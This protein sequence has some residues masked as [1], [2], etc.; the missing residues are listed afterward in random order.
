[1][2]AKT[3]GRK[4]RSGGLSQKAQ[5]GILIG[6]ACVLL[7]GGG[8]WGYFK[9]TTLP[10]PDLKAAPIN[11]VVAFMGNERGLIR[12]G[13]DQREQYL[14]QAYRHY[15]QG[16][17]RDQFI[18]QLNRMSPSEKQVLCDAVFDITH[19]KVVAA[20]RQYNDLPPSQRGAF[21]DNTIKQF[22]SMRNELG[23]GSAQNSVAQPMKS[24]L[25]TSSDE[26]SKI[27]VSRTSGQERAEAKPFVD[28]VA[29]RYKEMRNQ[30]R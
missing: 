12:M 29:A 28:R 1:M 3:P 10:P 17:A 9:L 20:A 16:P 22:D 11:D 15:S 6:C 4:G 7:L 18:Q 24:S 19:V 30:G 21:V 13:V 27:L 23:G 5:R 2:A 25:P 14:L 26:W 8:W